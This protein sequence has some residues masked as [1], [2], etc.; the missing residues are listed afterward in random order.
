[1]GDASIFVNL[2]EQVL[3]VYQMKRTS[4]KRLEVET[5]IV[6]LDLLVLCHPTNDVSLAPIF[7]NGEAFANSIPG[8]GSG[9]DKFVLAEPQMPG[10]IEIN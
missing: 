10:I 1:V 9:H 5:S 2:T 7:P 6:K 4:P 3:A 8:T